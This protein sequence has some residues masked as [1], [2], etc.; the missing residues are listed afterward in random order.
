MTLK[1]LFVAIF[2]ST[3]ILSV[4]LFAQ[5]SRQIL[6]NTAKRLNGKTMQATFKASTFSNGQNQN[7]NATG[8][9]YIKK[10]KFHIVTQ[11]LITWFD[12]KTLWQYVKSS[13]EVN[14]SNP[15]SSE[16]QKMNPYAFINLYKKGY[17]LSCKNTSLR[18]KSCYEI[19]LTAQNKNAA[20]PIMIVSIDK[21]YTPLCVRIKNGK[22]W[23][24]LSIYNLKTGIR[25]ADSQF[26]F[27]SSNYPEAQIIDL[28]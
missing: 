27:N 17:A 24:R 25:M 12:G 15:T 6:D 13:G 16:L 4:P 26:K 5:N 1:R 22:Q 21:N 9:I 8:Q 2:A 20:I 3:F 7:G 11:P 10:N 28:R 23:T 18:G 14:V 19:T